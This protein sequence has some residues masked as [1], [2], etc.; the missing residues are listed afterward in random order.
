M[1]LELGLAAVGADLHQLGGDVPLAAVVLDPAERLPVVHLAAGVRGGGQE[2]GLG[3]GGADQ[4][5][6]LLRAEL[7]P[8]QGRSAKRGLTLC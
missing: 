3:E 7:A 8:A 1:V 2:G 5:V 6:V 4:A